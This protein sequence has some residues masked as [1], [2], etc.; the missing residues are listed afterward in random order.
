MLLDEVLPPAM[1]HYERN[2]NRYRLSLVVIALKVFAVPCLLAQAALS[3]SLAPPVSSALKWLLIFPV[4][5]IVYWT[6][7]N[8]L[9]TL[10]DKRNAARL[11]AQPIPKV[12]GGWI[13]G[14]DLMVYFARGQEDNY[15]TLEF[16][17]FFEER[18]ATT[19]NFQ[20]MWHDLIM[21]IDDGHIKHVLSTGFS[22][23][24]KGPR[25]RW[26]M[27]GVFGNGIFNRDGDVWKMHRSMTRP[28]FSRDRISD[29]V[30]IGKHT[31]VALRVLSKLSSRSKAVD[32][33]DLFARFTID[34]AA[35]FL[36]GTQLNSLH[37][38]LP[39]PGRSKLGPKGS[40]VRTP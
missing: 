8:T 20:I 14:L 29:Y 21:T 27:E 36:F 7:R 17:K 23:F 11:G 24:E 16:R 1:F 4:S 34:A 18:G 32:V 9:W 25:G 31:D 22:H 19:L 28:F 5:I 30:T 40:Q 33:Q 35:E 13:G 39:E 10:R 12:Y 6:T 37:A 2:Y 15:G 3:L 26:I 38:P